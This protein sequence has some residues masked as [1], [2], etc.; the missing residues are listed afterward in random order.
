MQPTILVTHPRSR[1]PDYFGDEALAGLRR[2]A[3]VRLNELDDDLSGP[4]L[5][6]AAQGCAL[7]IAYRQ[8]PVDAVTFAAL[9]DL[10]AVVRCAVDIRAI[11]V[12]AASRHGVLVTQASAGFM[13][14]VSE[15]V[16][17]VMIDLSRNISACVAQYRAFGV[18]AA[19][20]GRE[21]RGAVLGVIGY[22]QI[23][24]YLCP[25]AHALGMRVLVHDPYVQ[26]QA[27]N[28]AQTGLEQLLAQ[29]D[30]VVCLAPAN[31]QT[32]NLM[33][34]HTFA[35]MKHGAF[36]I[37]AARGELVDDAALL[38]ALNSGHLGGAALDV[39]R[40][41]DQ[42]PTL[43]LATHPQ[44]LATPHIGGLT[45]VATRHQALET[46][47]QCADIVRGRVPTGA[48]NA[49]DATRWLQLAQA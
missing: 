12:A 49:A 46:V 3:R 39:G 47:V 6:A 10:A 35:T 11:D 29:A 8:T 38:H 28:V 4:S 13:A 31:A 25:V 26:V 19:V 14:A 27:V 42:M 20:M 2:I 36:F 21:L 16:I 40:A 1:L 45:P 48:V 18:A 9:P 17:A 33:N 15:W 44:V 5:I 34:T 24:R 32:E 41:T 23:S 30:Y 22:G 43:A 37:N 7:V